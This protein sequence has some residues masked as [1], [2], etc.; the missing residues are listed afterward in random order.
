MLIKF[1]KKAVSPFG[2]GNSTNVDDNVD[3][4]ASSSIGFNSD[5]AVDGRSARAFSNSTNDVADDSII[6]ADVDSD[7][8]GGSDGNGNGNGNGNRNGDGDGD[9]DAKSDADGDG[10]VNY[11]ANAA[12]DIDGTLDGRSTTSVDNPINI[13]TNVDFINFQNS[14]FQSLI[15]QHLAELANNSMAS[16]KLTSNLISFVLFMFFEEFKTKKNSFKKNISSAFL[17][18]GKKLPVDDAIVFWNSYLSK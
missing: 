3:A 9:S 7:A 12:V 8:D 15:I 1:N 6:N 17:G 16:T 14:E 2:I 10:D 5:G 13:D 4:N 11:N 18:K